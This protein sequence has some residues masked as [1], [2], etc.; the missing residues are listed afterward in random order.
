MAL[1][2]CSKCSTEFSRQLHRNMFLK[3]VTPW[4]RV[5]RFR[6]GKCLANRYVL[7]PRAY[8]LSIK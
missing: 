2:N 5:R 8:M 6:C 4:L 3:G 1:P 7:V